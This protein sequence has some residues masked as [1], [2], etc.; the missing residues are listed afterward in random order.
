VRAPGVELYTP[1]ETMIRK[2]VL[3]DCISVK[4][5]GKF[6]TVVTTVGWYFLAL[7][8]ASCVMLWIFGRWA[9]V[10]VAKAGTEAEADVERRPHGGAASDGSSSS[11]V[12]DARGSLAAAKTKAVN[13][14]GDDGGLVLSRRSPTHGGKGG[15]TRGTMAG[16]F[17]QSRF[18]KERVVVADRSL[19]K[20]FHEKLPGMSLE[21]L[22]ELQ[23]TWS[24]RKSAG[25]STATHSKVSDLIET[26][27]TARGNGVATEGRSTLA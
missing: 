26:E 7:F 8:G 23:E 20:D 11:D 19:E 4:L 6:W 27:I 13:E 24:D 12:G 3:T 22:R 25:Y 14:V 16:A 10:A 2:Y 5:D 9:A 17:L 18:A 21:Q 1:A 15:H